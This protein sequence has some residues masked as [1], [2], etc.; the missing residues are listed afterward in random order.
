MAETRP[1]QL[2]RVVALRP[3]LHC[4]GPLGVSFFS[5]GRV[6]GVRVGPAKCFPTRILSNDNIELSQ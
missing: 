2:C 6:T 3:L 4:G 5:P 1:K